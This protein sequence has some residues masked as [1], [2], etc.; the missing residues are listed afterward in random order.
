MLSSS[1]EKYNQE[2]ICTS[3]I[4]SLFFYLSI[5]YGQQLCEKKS[6]PMRMEIDTSQ[7]QQS[8]SWR[9]MRTNVSVDSQGRENPLSQITGSQV[10]GFILRS[11]TWKSVSLFCLFML[12]IDWMRPTLREENLLKS[13]SIPPQNTLKGTLGI[14]FG[15]ISV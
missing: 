15:Q 10:G 11:F 12:S 8:A 4:F 13:V 9:T 5:I 14:M 3:H 2:D 1:T 6:A 7:D